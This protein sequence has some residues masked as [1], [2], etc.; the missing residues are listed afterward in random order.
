MVPLAVV[1]ERKCTVMRKQ[2][3]FVLA[4][5]AQIIIVIKFH[6]DRFPFVAKR[7]GMSLLSLHL[8]F[9]FA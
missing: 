2:S 4:N 8:K 6:H 3:I 5:F 1:S 9:I 7:F